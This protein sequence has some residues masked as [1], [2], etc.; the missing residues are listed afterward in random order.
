MDTTPRTDDPY[1]TEQR[2]A[3]RRFDWQLF[4]ILIIAS[5]VAL[6][7]VLFF[8]FSQGT[9]APFQVVLLALFSLGEYL[10][11]GALAVGIGLRVGEPLGFG[12]PMLRDWL[13]GYRDASREFLLGLPVAIGLGLLAGA[14]FV[15]LTILVGPLV[16]YNF[17]NTNISSSPPWQEFLRYLEANIREE[18][19]FRLGIMTLLIWVGTQIFTPGRL[20]P[21]IIWAAVILSALASGIYHIPAYEALTGGITLLVILQNTILGVVYGWL[22]WRRGLLLAMVAHLC[23]DLVIHLIFPSLLLNIR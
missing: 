13:D 19:W 10:V 9:Y 21:K 14:I 7:P 2:P 20:S 18:L 3:R 5:L 1:Y 16:G 11:I 17:Q 12:V 22:Y 4:W 8:Y 15:G 23:A 6:L